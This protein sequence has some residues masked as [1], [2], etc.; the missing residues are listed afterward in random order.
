MNISIS[1]VAAIGVG[2]FK[3]DGNWAFQVPFIIVMVEV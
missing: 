2:I 3:I 1:I